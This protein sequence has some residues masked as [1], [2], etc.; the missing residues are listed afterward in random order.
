MLHDIIIIVHI[1]GWKDLL[2]QRVSIHEVLLR[3]Q[4]GPINDHVLNNLLPSLYTL[5]ENSMIEE[6]TQ[7]LRQTMH[8]AMAAV[9]V[10]SSTFQTLMKNLSQPTP[11]VPPAAVDETSNEFKYSQEWEKLKWSRVYHRQYLPNH[12]DYLKFDRL[13][14]NLTNN[15]TD[16]TVT[17]TVTVKA[18]SSEIVVFA[19]SESQLNQ[20]CV[21]YVYIIVQK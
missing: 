14:Q 2:E 8:H 11:A 19:P 16:S 5:E 17:A 21:G 15:K 7:M 13:F 1:I 9:G 18:G 4:G 3:L 20:V 12:Y 10:A 6:A